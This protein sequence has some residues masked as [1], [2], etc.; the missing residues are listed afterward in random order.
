[1]NEHASASTQPL[2]KSPQELAMKK[3]PKKDA[4]PPKKGK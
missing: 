2:E 4:K 3:K 1:M